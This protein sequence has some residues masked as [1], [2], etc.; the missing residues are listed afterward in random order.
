MR[1]EGIVY[2]VLR[3]SYQVKTGGTLVACTAKGTFRREEI[4][5][6]VGDHVELEGSVI[7]GIA[8][9]RNFLIRPPIANFDKL[10][11]VVATE[12]PQPSTLLVDKLTAIAEHKGAEPILVLNKI[13]LR[14]QEAFVQIYEKA[15][16]AVVCTDALQ[17][18][19]METLR[20]CLRGGM[21][22]FTGNT[23]VGKSSLLNALSPRLQ[24]QT[25]EISRKLGRGRHTT[26][27]VELIEVEEEMLVADTPG[28]S[29]VDLLQYSLVEKEALPY[30]FRDFAPYLGRCRFTS[31]SH[32]T[33]Q[34]CAV[35]AAM[36]RG[37]I[38]PSRVESY[39]CMYQELKDWKPWQMKKR[40]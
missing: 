13:D 23:G 3:D 10:A 34:G 16:F 40:V 37:E 38:A 24:L 30:A 33:E 25:G 36:E 11:I 12:H 35:L 14:R 28:F 20:A 6:V 22:V 9:R 39:R 4:S 29:T 19:G 21:T 31:C 8:P 15:G 7:A 32:T 1:R 17:G 18:V 27:H 2:K 5:P 26:R